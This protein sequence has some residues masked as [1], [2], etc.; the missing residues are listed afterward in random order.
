MFP[1]CG[2]LSTTWHLSFLATIDLIS[3]DTHGREIREVLFE[4]LICFR[5]AQV[6]RRSE[7]EV[8]VDTR[9]EPIIRFRGFE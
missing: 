9:E 7:K 6:Q 2:Y 8:W 3:F 5:N 4:I 1:S